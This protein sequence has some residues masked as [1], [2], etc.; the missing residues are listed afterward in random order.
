MKLDNLSV[1][2]TVT[3]VYFLLE[4]DIGLEML[5]GDRVLA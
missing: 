1:I 4:R 3:V 5:L 2:K